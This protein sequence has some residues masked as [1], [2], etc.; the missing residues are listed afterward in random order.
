MAR[1]DRIVIRPFYPWDDPEHFD[2]QTSYDVYG[3]LPGVPRGTR[4]ELSID[5]SAYGFAHA[6]T[7]PHGWPEGMVAYLMGYTSPPDVPPQGGTFTYLP[8]GQPMQIHVPQHKFWL[9]GE[10]PR[11]TPGPR[12]VTLPGVTP[13]KGQARVATL[14]GL[15]KVSSTSFL[16]GRR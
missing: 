13:S 11:G 4:V 6:N 7:Y 10:G 14:A 9:E 1:I 2:L 12:G 5:P 15:G 8:G 3:D 16:M